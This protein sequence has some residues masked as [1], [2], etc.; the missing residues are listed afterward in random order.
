MFRCPNLLCPGAAGRRFW[1][2][3]AAVRKCR[4]CGSIPDE[5]PRARDVGDQALAIMVDPGAL[6]PQDV[7]AVNHP[8]FIRFTGK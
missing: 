2:L 6:R 3:A 1:G 8:V 4:F 5:T 7:A